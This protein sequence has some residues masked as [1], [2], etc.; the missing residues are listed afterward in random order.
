M[1]FGKMY[2]YGQI[3]L[4]GLCRPDAPLFLFFHCNT[5]TIPIPISHCRSTIRRLWT[6]PA[7]R[8]A[9]C[10]PRRELGC[11]DGVAGLVWSGFLLV[12]W[13]DEVVEE[14]EEEEEAPRVLGTL[15]AQSITVAV[16]FTLRTA[17]VSYLW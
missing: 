7:V 14:E 9:I 5:P 12:G 6:R 2:I 13:V 17:Q 11:G 1:L 10:W 4:I 8:A 15:R 16:D 3:Y